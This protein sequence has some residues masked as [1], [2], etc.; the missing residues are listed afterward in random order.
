[1]KVLEFDAGNTRLKWRLLQVNDNGR[2]RIAH[3]YLANDQ[4]WQQALAEL[5]TQ[6]GPVDCAR[7]AVVSGDARFQWLCA[8]V[9]D[10]L[11]IPVLQAQVK[12]VWRGVQVAYPEIGVDRWL[13]MLAAHHRGGTGNKLVVSCGT[14]MTVDVLSGTGRHL[15]GFIVPGVGLMK[16]SLH[17]NTARLPLVADAAMAVSPGNNTM[18][19]INNGALAMAVAMINTQQADAFAA[20]ENINSV[21][22]VTGGDAA[23]VKPFIQGVCLEYPELVMDGLALAFDDALFTLD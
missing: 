21:V 9:D 5:L 8:A 19:C 23:V 6:S 20:E 1:M 3:G 18:E 13:A 16:Q 12:P 4:C 17:A 14:A 15:G 22:Y 2:K 11:H 7:A 10:H